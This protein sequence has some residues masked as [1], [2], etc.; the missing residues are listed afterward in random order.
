MQHGCECAIPHPNLV[1]DV[2]RV[3][4]GDSPSL[5]GTG[6]PQPGHGKKTLDKSPTY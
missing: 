5:L 1:F 4:A 2:L 3:E 6:S